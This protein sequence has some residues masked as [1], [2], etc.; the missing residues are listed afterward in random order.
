MRFIF[1]LMYI[2]QS[3]FLGSFLISIPPASPVE[4]FELA[5]KK[6]APPDKGQ[7]NQHN[8]AGVCQFG[9]E[10][11]VLQ[12]PEGSEDVFPIVPV[13]LFASDASQQD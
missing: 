1:L 11:I 6:V 9:Q 2:A 13:R 7:N 3:L 8:P 10:V 5:V 12:P 4:I